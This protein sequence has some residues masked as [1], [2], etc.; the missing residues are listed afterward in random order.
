[1]TAPGA[2]SVGELGL[3][4]PADV[5]PHSDG[6][7]VSWWNEQHNG[8][9]PGLVLLLAALGFALVGRRRL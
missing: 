6:E 9:A 8:P 1:M 5:G 4:R 2:G 7:K 3:L